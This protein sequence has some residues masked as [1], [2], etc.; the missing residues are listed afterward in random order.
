MAEENCWL[1]IWV[2]KK[3]SPK[4]LVHLLV[5]ILLGLLEFAKNGTKPLYM[6]TALRINLK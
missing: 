5:M 2:F 6:L 4:Q 1:Y 3:W